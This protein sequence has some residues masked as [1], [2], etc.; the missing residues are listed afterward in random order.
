[1]EEWAGRE[2]AV[3]FWESMQIVEQGK[4]DRWS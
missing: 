4:A 2:K 1:M 3:S